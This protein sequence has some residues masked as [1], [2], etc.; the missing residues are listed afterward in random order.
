MLPT[1]TDLARQSS[2][3][4]SRIANKL[5]ALERE[6]FDFGTGEKLHPFEINLIDAIGQKHGR[7]VS[8]LA[9]WFHVT[10]GAVSQVVGR[11]E[12]LGYLAKKKILKTARW[13]G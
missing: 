9:G 2:V 12:R 6:T 3:L 13:S 10:A 5:K 7:T 1:R 11:L 8:E 4:I